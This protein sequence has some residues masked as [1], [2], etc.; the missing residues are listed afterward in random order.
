M[1]A[2]DGFARRLHTLVPG[3]HRLRARLADKVCSSVAS[4]AS[5]EPGVKL[6]RHLVVLDGAGIGTGSLF[7]G[8]ETITLGRRLK[9]GP[10][11]MFITNDHPIP[12]DRQ[13]FS[14]LRGTNRPIVVGDDV[15]IGAGSLVLAGV[16]IGDGAAV[17]AGSVV[18]R[19][20][21]PGAVVVGAPAKIV[22]T[23]KV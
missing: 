18:V 8:N 2:Y 7:T 1:V 13:R 19:D 11:C 21:P 6:S 20:V 23:R 5:I 10:R 16:T 14:E 22:R 3:G 15:F 12:A 4:T 9:M 17:G